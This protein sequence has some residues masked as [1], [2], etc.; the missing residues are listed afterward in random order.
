MAAKPP[1]AKKAIGEEEA[2]AESGP[3]SRELARGAF[4]K[5]PPNVVQAVTSMVEQDLNPVADLMWGPTAEHATA[6]VLGLMTIAEAIIGREGGPEAEAA[7]K[8]S[9]SARY[10]LHHA[11]QALLV[12]GQHAD[13]A[14]AY[15]SLA[16]LYAEGGLHGQM[17]YESACAARPQAASNREAGKKQREIYR[18]WA[19]AVYKHALAGGAKGAAASPEAADRHSKMKRQ[20]SYQV[21]TSP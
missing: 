8:S 12:T 6:V 19:E 10:A 11:A 2:R 13:A 14:R 5:L 7:I 9:V 3:S 17:L 1:K 21:R 15:G 4:S 20:P 16:R 18:F